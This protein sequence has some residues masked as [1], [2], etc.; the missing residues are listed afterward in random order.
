MSIIGL[1]RKLHIA[2]DSTDGMRKVKARQ[3]IR[4]VILRVQTI[5]DEIYSGRSFVTSSNLP[6]FTVAMVISFTGFLFS[7]RVIVPVTP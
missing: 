2:P 1:S 3:T 7:S 4:R 5:S 6:F